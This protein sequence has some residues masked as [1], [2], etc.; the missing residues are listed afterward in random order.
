MAIILSITSSASNNQVSE[1]SLPQSITL[2]ANGTDDNSGVLGYY[3]AI[4]DKPTGSSASLSSKAG[5]TV[6]LN[7]VDVWGTYRVFCIARNTSTQE[8]TATDPFRAPAE[9]FIDVSVVESSVYGLEKPAKGERNYFNK[10]WGLYDAVK[11]I[12]QNSAS[13]NAATDVKGIVELADT[14]EIKLGTT[15]GGTGAE[16][17]LTASRLYTALSESLSGTALQTAC[18]N[19]TKNSSIQNLS[20]VAVATPTLGDVLEWSGS[21]WTPVSPSAGAASSYF[22]TGINLNQASASSSATISSGETQIKFEDGST[23]ASIKFSHTDKEFIVSHDV[24][25]STSN[26]L[27]LGSQTNP[28]QNVFTYKVN[29]ELSTSYIDMNASNQNGL[30]GFITLSG[31]SGVQ[32]LVDTDGNAGSGSNTQ[33]FAVWSGATDAGSIGA[34]N[35]FS[36]EVT[37]TG[38]TDCAIKMYDAYT[39]PTTDGSANQVLSTNGTGQLSWVAQSGGGA[40]DKISELNTSVECIDTGTDGKIVLETEGSERWHVTSGGHLIPQTNSAYDIGSAE[41]KVR[42]LYLSNNSLKFGPSENSNVSAT[43]SVDGTDLKLNGT[44][45]FLAF[46]GVPSINQVPQW[47]GSAWGMTDLPSSSSGERHTLTSNLN[48]TFTEEIPYNGSGY[49]VGLGRSPA[50]F[51][52]KNDSGAAWNLKEFSLACSHMH[53]S[54][55]TFSFVTCTTAQYLANTYTTISSEYTLA[56]TNIDPN[57]NN[58]G[59]GITENALGVSIP[60]GNWVIM[61]LNTFEKTGQDNNQFSLTLSYNF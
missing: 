59:I 32:C 10:T 12:A 5:Q 36:I 37:G 38:A 8:T 46:S 55:L 27:T 50:M 30:G 40:T 56:K 58:E 61:F 57:T 25:P 34:Q 42:H 41:L 4:M 31:A 43:V 11:G 14:E 54:S 3:W 1:S 23:D 47:D 24:V 44:Q 13:A 22:T 6:T 28:F 35:R 49:T 33:G 18:Q 21:E 60:S 7:D 29:S 17:V 45:T 51:A 48:G 26:T 16:T 20:D 15:L 39:F 9:N 52:F 2:T 19:I 53:S